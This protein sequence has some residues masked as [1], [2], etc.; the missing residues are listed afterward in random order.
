MKGDRRTYR[1]PRAPRPLSIGPVVQIAASILFSLFLAGAAVQLH[2]HATHEHDPMRAY[3]VLLLLPLSIVIALIVILS[4][5]Q[6]QRPHAA[7][8]DS[9]NMRLVMRAY[10]LI[11]VFFWIVAGFL[12]Y[13]F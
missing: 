7:I 11:W 10:W 6:R 3:A 8:Q 2:D 12:A 1:R 13:A 4:G 9:L 5:V